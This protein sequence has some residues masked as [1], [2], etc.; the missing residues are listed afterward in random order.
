MNIEELGRDSNGRVSSQPS[1]KSGKNRG[2][3]QEEVGGTWICASG[4]TYEARQES[5]FAHVGWIKAVI[6]LGHRVG[7]LDNDGVKDYYIF[8]KNNHEKG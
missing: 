4:Y 8:K 5:R 1:I 3:R 7:S 2:F 6:Q